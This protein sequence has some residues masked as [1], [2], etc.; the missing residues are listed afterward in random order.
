MRRWKAKRK[1]KCLLEKQSAS[2]KTRVSSA[3]EVCLW[4]VYILYKGMVFP[5]LCLP[6]G[7]L[8]SPPATA[9]PSPRLICLKTFPRS[10][11][12]RWISMQ[13]HLGGQ[14]QDFLWPG[15]PWI[16]IP[17]EPLCTGVLSP[18]PQGQGYVISW[19]FAQARF[20]PSLFLH[21]C[22]LNMSTRDK[23]GIFIPASVVPSISESKQEA[24]CKFLTWSPL[25]SCLRQCKQEASFKGQAWSPFFLPHEM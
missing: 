17:K 4:E 3:K 22:S 25:I 23:A 21:D 9:P 12:K 6:T 7:Q 20:S 24:E 11:W 13:R 1:V 19:F 14:K 15:I 10:T 16:L 8:G 2:G 5:S 18:L